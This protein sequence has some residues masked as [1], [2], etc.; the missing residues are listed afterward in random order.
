VRGYALFLY[1]RSDFFSAHPLLS[2]AHTRCPASSLLRMWRT[3]YPTAF[4][5]TQREPVQVQL[6]Q[7]FLPTPAAHSQSCPLEP[8][9]E[10]RIASAS[11]STSMSHLDP[12]CPSEPGFDTVTPLHPSRPSDRGHTHSATAAAAAAAALTTKPTP[13]LSWSRVFP[14]CCRWFFWRTAR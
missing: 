12:A 1:P 6:L 3:L 4:R 5:T 9:Q 8:S 7:H 2:S 11:T 10:G 14:S 13:T